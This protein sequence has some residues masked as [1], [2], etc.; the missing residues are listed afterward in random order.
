MK[1][2]KGERAAFNEKAVKETLV[3]MQHLRDNCI[4]G[5]DAPIYHLQACLFEIK[6]LRM[7]VKTLR[8]LQARMMKTSLKL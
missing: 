3:E 5:L 1:K 7:Q 2:K 6:E 4:A 8:S